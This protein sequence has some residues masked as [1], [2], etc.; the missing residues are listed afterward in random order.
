[1]FEFTVDN[2]ICLCLV[3]ES[4]A[5]DYVKLAKDNFEYLSK[6]LSWPEVCQTE[7]DFNKFIRD[8]LDK[9]DDGECMNCAIKYNGEIVGNIGF[10][11]INH[12]VK[13]TDIGY[14]ISEE[15]QGRGIVTR[16]CRFLINYAFTELNLEKVQI[17]AIKE[18]LSSRAVCERLGMRL[19]GII[20]NCEKVGDRILD[21]AIY[22]IHRA[23]T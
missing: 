19:E 18:N 7:E 2:D 3:H 10:N 14:W 8:S 11:V 9:Y 13:K 4:F 22:G 17:R 21:H 20:T 12:D 1:M 6:W 16:S 5:K 15:V 23:E